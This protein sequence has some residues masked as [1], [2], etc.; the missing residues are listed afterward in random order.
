MK[1]QINFET[2]IITLQVQGLEP[3]AF[4]L[5]VVNCIQPVQ[6]HDEVDLVALAAEV[7]Q[8]PVDHVLAL[9]GAVDGDQHVPARDGEAAHQNLLVGPLV[10]GGGFSGGE[11]D[12]LECGVEYGRGG[13]GEGCQLLFTLVC[14]DVK[15]LGGKNCE[16]YPL[17]AQCSKAQLT[18]WPCWRCFGFVW[19]GWMWL[20]LLA[21]PGLGQIKTKKE[22]L[23]GGGGGDTRSYYAL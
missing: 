20:S 21:S 1:L 4:K 17:P 6:P 11:G 18:T 15:V 3:C 10:V 8:R 13:R 12:L 5:W 9:R 16:I 14:F 7:G 2:R 22:K 23:G 19:M